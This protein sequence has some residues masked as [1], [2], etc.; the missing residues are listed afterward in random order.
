MIRLHRYS[1][2]SLNCQSRSELVELKEWGADLIICYGN[3][4]RIALCLRGKRLQN[5]K[6]FPHKIT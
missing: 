2:A 6:Q 5:G 1:M 4:D 3:N